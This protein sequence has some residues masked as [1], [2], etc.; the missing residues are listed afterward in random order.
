MDGWGSIPG[1]GK[2]FFSSPQNPDRL[3]S[4]HSLLSSAVR[5]PGHEGDHSSPSLME[6]KNDGAIPLL[7]HMSS[8]HRAQ[9][10]THRENFTFIIIIIHAFIFFM[11]K[12]TAINWEVYFCSIICNCI[13]GLMIW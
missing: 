4:P 12:R 13:R 6:D 1:R 5:R 2:R 10:I 8:R 9:L 7:P 11:I 3:W